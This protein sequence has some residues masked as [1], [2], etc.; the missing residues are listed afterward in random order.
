MLA[1]ICFLIVMQIRKFDQYLRD[2]AG[3][4]RLDN[5]DLFRDIQIERAQYIRHFVSVGLWTVKEREHMQIPY[6]PL[7][8][9]AI[10][11]CHCCEDLC[12]YWNIGQTPDR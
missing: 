11:F 2:F 5:S 4:Q 9:I 12:E 3:I 1:P 10:I 7:E 6:F 8:D